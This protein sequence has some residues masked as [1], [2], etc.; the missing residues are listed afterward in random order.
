MAG[1]FSISAVF[2]GNDTGLARVISR[3]EARASKMARGF[4]AGWEGIERANGRLFDSFN[5]LGGKIAKVGLTLGGIGLG[6]GLYNV[7]KTAADYEQA[8]TNVGAVS[9]L[10]RDQIQDLES[11]TIQLA[12]ETKFT[13]TEVAG[14]MELMGKAGFTNAQILEGIDGVLAAAAAEGITIEETAGHVSNVLKGMGLDNENMGA[15]AGRVADVLALASART[16][17]SISSLGESMA[18]VSATARQLNV[19]LEQVVAGVAMLQDVGLDASVAGSAMNTMLTQ[20]ATPTASAAAKMRQWGISFKDVKTGDMLPF[21]DVLGQLSK[22]AK[23]S[24]GNFDQV[25]FFADLVGLRGQKAAANL[26]DLFNSGK[27]QS[28]A[29]ELEGAAGSAKKMADIRL[30]TLTGDITL[31]GSSFDLVKIAAFDAAGKGLRPL[32]QQATAWLN[33]N[34]DLIASKS[35]EY[36]HKFVDALPTIAYWLEKVGRAAL[37]LYALSAALKAVQISIALLNTNPATVGFVA[38]LAAITAIVTFWPEIKG[39][40]NEHSAAIKGTV[41][42]LGILAAAANLGKVALIA[43]AVA[44]NWCSIRAIAFAAKVAI[45][46]TAQQLYA[47]AT[48]GATLANSAFAASVLAVMGPVLAVTAAIGSLIALYNQLGS[49]SNESE[50]LGITGIISQMIKQGTWNPFTAVDTYMNEQA[51]NRATDE[52]RDASAQA[53]PK[54]VIGAGEQGSRFYS[55]VNTNQTSTAEVTIRD[56]SGR[57]QI[58]KL[59]RKPLSINLQPSGAF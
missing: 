46:T 51:R 20:M 56:E 37:T 3:I 1:R 13:A 39:F 49:L 26:K 55:E 48:G 6:A 50:G 5:R 42:A 21:I 17:S 7:A 58:T 38:L 34:K 11:K 36:L 14:A 27:Y 59:P 22:A 15:N 41:T 45:A 54:Q 23:K 32:A 25:A 9:L 12:K 18:N 44:M 57:A 47:V 2:G 4:S 53:V 16:N 10:T 31:L 24:G 8:I 40:Y 19:P 33:T 28:L 30:N 35:A 29:K 52:G 43:N